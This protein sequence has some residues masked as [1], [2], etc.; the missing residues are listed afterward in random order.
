[1]DPQEFLSAVFQMAALNNFAVMLE[2]DG[3][4]L[5][6]I[7]D[8]EA[9]GAFACAEE[10]GE[11]PRIIH[12]KDY[13]H[14]VIHTFFDA[15]EDEEDPED[16]GLRMVCWAEM[17][18]DKYNQTAC[19]WWRAILDGRKIPTFDADGE[20]EFPPIEEVCE[21][22]MEEAK[23]P[24]KKATHEEAIDFIRKMSMLNA[25]GDPHGLIDPLYTKA[26]KDF[27]PNRKPERPLTLD[28]WRGLTRE[29]DDFEPALSR[30]ILDA[31][32]PFVFLVVLRDRM[33]FSAGCADAVIS[34]ISVIVDPHIDR[35]TLQWVQ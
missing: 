3:E 10:E 11:S 17:G 33:V 25:D 8:P 32:D 24:P 18:P 14:F 2:R 31:T 12:H 20:R 29:R 30:D 6:S 28:E 27:D 19:Q 1:M 22:G 26:C 4:A 7:D 16:P 34:I 9:N 23:A 21:A 5:G 15:N 13:G 35:R